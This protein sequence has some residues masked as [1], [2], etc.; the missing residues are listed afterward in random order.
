MTFRTNDVQ[1]AG[2]KHLF[3]F[4][5]NLLPEFGDECFSHRAK[6]DL[7]QCA[8]GQYL[9]GCKRSSPGT[10]VSCP[11]AVTVGK[12]FWGATG[13]GVASC[14][15]IPCSIP[16][17]GHFIKTECTSN[18]DAVI[19]SC[20]EYPGNKQSTK[21][22]SA[23]QLAAVTAGQKGVFDVDRFYCPAGNMV[24]PLPAN[25]ITKDYISF[26]CKPGFYLNEGVCWQCPPGS[27]CMN[28]KQ[29]VCPVNYYSRALSSTA[30]TLCTSSCSG[31][32]RKPLRCRAGSTF[33]A[34]CV[35]CGACGYSADVGLSCVE[36]DY[37]MKQ[38]KQYCSPPS[39]GEW[40][41]NN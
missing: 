34:G 5:R 17:P 13:H 23:E 27:A 15:L 37:E 28:G 36:N 20:A 11:E 4:F 39:T 33:D 14:T 30:C 18:T 38:M 21:D 41:C 25:S 6:C 7:T 19:K 9:S 32:N 10:C 35:S 16:T 22:M 31:G 24:V 8:R 40:Q 26:E 3:S 29:T 1:T 12:Q 2:G